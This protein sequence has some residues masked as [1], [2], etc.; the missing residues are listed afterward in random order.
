MLKR[1][2][3][4]LFAVAL[5]A[6]AAAAATNIVR[7]KFSGPEISGTFAFDALPYLDDTNPPGFNF[8]GSFWDSVHLTPGAVSDTFSIST[9]YPDGT[10]YGLSVVGPKGS[11][12]SSLTLAGVRFS[13]QLGTLN[14]FRQPSGG[15]IPEE[16]FESSTYDVIVSAAIPE[17]ATWGLM[18][19]G[20]GATGAALRRRQPAEA[21]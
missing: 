9:V 17:P 16:E 12:F 18:I 6:D 19:L 3:I 13:N 10:F 11:L 5:S 1:V 15:A 14:I 2:L 7:G 8:F 21:S 20:V 4:G